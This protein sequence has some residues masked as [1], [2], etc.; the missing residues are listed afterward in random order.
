MCLSSPQRRSFIVRRSQT[1]VRKH[2]AI[3]VPFTCVR[4]LMLWKL[5]VERKQRDGS[6]TS[7]GRYRRGQ[8]YWKGRMF[9]GS[10]GS[11]RVLTYE[12]L[13]LGIIHV[14][15]QTALC[16]CVLKCVCWFYQKPLV[17]QREGLVGNEKQKETDEAFRW[18]RS[19]NT[20]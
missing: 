3:R 18:E 6:S 7:W 1:S 13:S 20:K 9:S 15:M 16:V 8:G 19:Q 14:Y 17:K 12:G 5:D 10:M 2:E 4:S 11:C